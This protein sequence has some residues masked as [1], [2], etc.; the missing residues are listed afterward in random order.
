MRLY[1]AIPIQKKNRKLKKILEKSYKISTGNRKI[2]NIE[3]TE[4]D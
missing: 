4:A 2:K 1:Y 3:V